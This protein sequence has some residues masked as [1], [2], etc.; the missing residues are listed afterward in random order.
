LYKFILSDVFAQIESDPIY[1]LFF[2]QITGLGLRLEK[3]MD[4]LIASLGSSYMYEINS[5][6]NAIITLNR[7]NNFIGFAFRM[8]NVIVSNVFYLQ[9][10]FDNFSNLRL[11]NNSNLSIV[12][13]KKITL[14]LEVQYKLE[15]I[16]PVTGLEREET[17][18]ANLLNWSF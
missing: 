14:G 2:R 6:P 1:R 15:T 7:W 13:T 3:R 9:P 17:K 10:A 11:L 5:V 12:L 8:D 4:H 18:V 16:Y